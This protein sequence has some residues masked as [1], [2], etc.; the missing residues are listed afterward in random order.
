MQAT[1]GTVSLKGDEFDKLLKLVAAG[2][3][4]TVELWSR[5]SPW[6]FP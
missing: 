6:R 1:N 3:E 2:D 4:A 5:E